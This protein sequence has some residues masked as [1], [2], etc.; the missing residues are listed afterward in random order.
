MIFR[1]IMF[2]R[3]AA[4]TCH[5][6]SKERRE[7]ANLIGRLCQLWLPLSRQPFVVRRWSGRAVAVLMLACTSEA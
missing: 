4:R 1:S 3:A 2:F 6:S 7:A 5:H